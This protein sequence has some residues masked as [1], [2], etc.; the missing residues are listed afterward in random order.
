MRSAALVDFSESESESE[1]KPTNAILLVP[2]IVGVLTGFT[3]FWCW[4]RNIEFEFNKMVICRFIGHW[5][6]VGELILSTLVWTEYGTTKEIVDETSIVSISLLIL[7]L[8]GAIGAILRLINFYQHLLDQ[9][10]VKYF[11]RL[12]IFFNTRPKWTLMKI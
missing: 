4:W 11:S 8:I 2:V 5:I 10:K 1:V 9:G 7:I 3:Y 12:Q 6:A